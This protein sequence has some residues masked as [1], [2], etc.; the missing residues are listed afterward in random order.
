M[1]GDAAYHLFYSK[2]DAFSQKLI[3]FK[4]RIVAFY[5]LYRIK[6]FVKY[7]HFLLKWNGIETTKNAPIGFMLNTLTPEAFKLI[8]KSSQ[9]HAHRQQGLAQLDLYLINKPINLGFFKFN[10]KIRGLTLFSVVSG[11]NKLKDFANLPDR[12]TFATPRQAMESMIFPAQQWTR[13]LAKVKV[14]VKKKFVT[15]QRD[16]WLYA[17]EYCQAM[18]DKADYTKSPAY[19]YAL[20]TFN[21]FSSMM[22]APYFPPEFIAWLEKFEQQWLNFNDAQFSSL[23]NLLKEFELLLK[24]IDANNVHHHDEMTK[25]QIL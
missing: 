7:T 17:R 3:G 25:F 23:D 20:M 13:D 12:T 24:D 2:Y 22:E 14:G 19:N 16:L 6:F 10:F 4:K 9:P 8:P 11:K 21:I 1:I 15:N 5:E 18:P